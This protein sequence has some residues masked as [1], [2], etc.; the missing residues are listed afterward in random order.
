M[1]TGIRIVTL[2]ATLLGGWTWAGTDSTN[3]PPQT[4]RLELSLSDG[5]RV[6]REDRQVR[7]YIDG[8][9][10]DQSVHNGLNIKT[11]DKL[12]VGTSTMGQRRFT[13]II[14]DLMVFDRALS[15]DEIETLCGSK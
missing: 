10:R 9:L 15:P 2:A 8:Q 7:L 11:D 4:L 5:S 12:T 3:N 6:T 13:G 14:D 1:K